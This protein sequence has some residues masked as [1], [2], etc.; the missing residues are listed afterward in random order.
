MLNTKNLDT[1]DRVNK[2]GLCHLT[3]GRIQITQAEFQIAHEY[4]IAQLDQL[5]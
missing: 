1:C 5:L 2:F 4:I 3:I